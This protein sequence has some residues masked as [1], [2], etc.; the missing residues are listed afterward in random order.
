MTWEPYIINI[1]CECGTGRGEVT[2]SGVGVI[3]PV[4][5]CAQGFLGQSFS[6]GEGEAMQAHIKMDIHVSQLCN[7]KITLHNW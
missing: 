7:E 3:C 5:H 4:G 1:V 6:V 2:R